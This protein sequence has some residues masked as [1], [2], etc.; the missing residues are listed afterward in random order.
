[1][2]LA[3]NLN[4]K[5]LARALSH[6]AYIVS[7]LMPV[8]TLICTRLQFVARVIYSNSNSFAPHELI[9][10]RRCSRDRMSL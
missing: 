10:C 1:L 6:S 9:G 8:L 2:N 7:R 4:V 3:V 5:H